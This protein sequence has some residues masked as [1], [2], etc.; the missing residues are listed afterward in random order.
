MKIGDTGRLRPD[1][2]FAARTRGG[3]RSGRVQPDPSPSPLAAESGGMAFQLGDWGEEL[4]GSDPVV[5]RD[6]RT[7]LKSPIPP[8][9]GGRS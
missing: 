6:G 1:G 8:P 9:T 7:D 3:A 2:F 5:Q 4:E